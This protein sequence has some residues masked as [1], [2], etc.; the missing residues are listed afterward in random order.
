MSHEVDWE[1]IWDEFG[2]HGADAA[3]VIAV[4][5]N[6]LRT[7]LALSE[8]ARGDPEALLQSAVESDA[9]NAVYVDGDAGGQLL[10]GYSLGVNAR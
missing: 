8:H 5:Q 6:K 7:A 9:L 1:A 3:G 4:S 2:F 10:R